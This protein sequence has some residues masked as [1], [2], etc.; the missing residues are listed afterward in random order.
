MTVGQLVT[1][2]LIGVAL[3][4]SHAGTFAQTAGNLI[5]VGNGPEQTT[6]EALARAFEKVNPRAYVDILWDEDSKPL[7]SVKTGQAHIAVTGVE[8][9]ALAATQIG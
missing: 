3:C 2:L 6:I 5:I 9:P 4:V 7:Q 1:G 8:D